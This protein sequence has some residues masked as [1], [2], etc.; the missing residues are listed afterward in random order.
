MA[1]RPLFLF[2][3]V[4]SWYRFECI[5]F[6]TET[7]KLKTGDE[8]WLYF[9]WYWWNWWPSQL[10]FSFHNWSK[11]IGIQMREN[12][13]KYSPSMANKY[14]AILRIN[15]YFVYIEYPDMDNKTFIYESCITIMIRNHIMN[16]VPL[17][18]CR[19][20]YHFRKQN[21]WFLP[22]Q[23]FFSYITAKAS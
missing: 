4:T 18:G 2:P 20:T 13:I 3:R 12:L 16:Q 19:Y 21:E 14:Y 15:N 23:S 11:E 8:R 6:S 5:T 17:Y 1:E 10:K 7:T 9:C 22:T